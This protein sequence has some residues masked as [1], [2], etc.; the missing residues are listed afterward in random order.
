VQKEFDFVSILAKTLLKD[1]RKMSC[2]YCFVDA[3]IR[4]VSHEESTMLERR[5]SIL[6][7][8]KKHK[9]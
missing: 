2:N 8:G 4:Q 5:E 6:S 9:K 7:G 1:K 3:E